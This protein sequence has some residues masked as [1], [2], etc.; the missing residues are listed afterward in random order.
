MVKFIVFIVAYL[1]T[2]VTPLKAQD[3]VVENSSYHNYPITDSSIVQFCDSNTDF[4]K[5]VTF[6]NTIK[7]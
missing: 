1:I 7:D 4:E 2:L 6:E 5:D 3:Q